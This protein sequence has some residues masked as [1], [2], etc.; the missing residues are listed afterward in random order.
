MDL[1]VHGEKKNLILE[2]NEKQDLVLV[3]VGALKGDAL[4]QYLLNEIDKV[5]DQYPDKKVIVCFRGAVNDKR[6]EF[7]SQL[8]E[9]ADYLALVKKYNFSLYQVV[10]ARL[11]LSF[12][13]LINY[14][15]GVYEKLSIRKG[16]VSFIPLSLV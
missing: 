15:I 1:L 11:S 16:I 14:S 13:F 7:L 10:K 5:V 9:K 8:N 2:K 4:N 12:T 6:I 3:Y